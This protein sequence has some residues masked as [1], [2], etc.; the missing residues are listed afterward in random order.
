[1]SLDRDWRQHCLPEEAVRRYGSG[2]FGASVAD[3]AVNGGFRSASDDDIQFLSTLCEHSQCEGSTFALG[4]FSALGTHTGEDETGGAST[5]V[6]SEFTPGGVPE[7][8]TWAMLLA[9]FG[10]LGLAAYLRPRRSVTAA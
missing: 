3:P 5:L 10:G 1:L 7:V 2:R 8:S 6:I 4:A 9:G